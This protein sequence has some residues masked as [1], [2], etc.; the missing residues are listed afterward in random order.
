MPNKLLDPRRTEDKSPNNQL[1]SGIGVRLRAPGLEEGVRNKVRV[2]GGKGKK[3]KRCRGETKE[4]CFA[5]QKVREDLCG[6][7]FFRVP[8]CRKKKR[9]VEMAELRAGTYLKVVLCGL[10]VGPGSSGVARI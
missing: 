4:S 1:D 5:W 3:E 10:Q 7:K 9:V 2:V 6:N 8:D